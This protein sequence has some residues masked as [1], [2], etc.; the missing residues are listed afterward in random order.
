MNISEEQLP[1]FL[2]KFK[3]Y[4]GY[5]VVAKLVERCPVDTGFLRNSINFSVKDEKLVISMAEYGQ[6]IEF[7]TRPHLIV[8][9]DAKA[10]HWKKGGKDFFAKSVM[11]P[12]TKPNPFI[13]STFFQD[14][15]SLSQAAANAA[16]NDITGATT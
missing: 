2:E 10:L 13:R 5:L 6:H 16:Y 9:K 3:H 15:Q 11:H 7:G 1:V 14:L 4:L 12:G 8:A